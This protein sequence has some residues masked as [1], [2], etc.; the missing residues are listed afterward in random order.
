MSSR[1]VNIFYAF[2]DFCGKVKR[3]GHSKY[4]DKK[5]GISI[6]YVYSKRTWAAY[7]SV[8]LSFLDYLKNNNVKRVDKITKEHIDGFM[9]Q[10]LDNAKRTVAK[11]QSALNKFL[12]FLAKEYGRYDLYKY[13][14]SNIYKRKAK[15]EG[16]KTSSYKN[17]ELIIDYLKQKNEVF[18]HIARLQYYA[19]LRVQEVVRCEVEGTKLIIKR[20][21]GGLTR[22]IDFSDRTEKLEKI[23]ESI[24][25][26]SSHYD[27]S[28][29]NVIEKK[30]YAK[31]LKKVCNVLEEE[32]SGSHGLRFNYA[33]ERYIE[34]LEKTNY[35]ISFKENTHVRLKDFTN[36]EDYLKAKF[37]D[38]D[39][40]KGTTVYVAD[41]I[42]S[43]ELGHRRWRMARYYAKRI[44]VSAIIYL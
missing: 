17:P 34:L 36:R 33:E 14:K 9:Q 44:D 23:K 4:L 37:L 8:I 29:W 3:F 20:S 26:V 5:H 12:Y 13:S 22:A 19:G 2:H 7:K 21:K 10:Y 30:K 18:G 24:K 25:V 1:K 27:K 38:K 40:E 42:L 32:Y 28:S 6:A 16:K 35:E 31:E 39:S 43:K 15:K 41:I 11:I